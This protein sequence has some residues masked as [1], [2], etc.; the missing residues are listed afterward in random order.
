MQN[1][2]KII[3]YIGFAA[4]ANKI[5]FGTDRILVRPRVPVIVLSGNAAENTTK[6][7]SSYAEKSKSPVVILENV[8]LEEIL[9]KNNCK[10]VAVTDRELANAII[11]NVL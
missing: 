10:V 3:S 9:K 11:E 5:V 8:T 1:T 6:K 2:G 7:I 4:R